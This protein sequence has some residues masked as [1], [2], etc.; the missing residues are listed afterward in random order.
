M[1]KGNDD[2]EEGNAYATTTDDWTL[3]DEDYAALS[4]SIQA[5]A[6]NLKG[7]DADID[8]DGEIAQVPLGLSA[9]KSERS[10]RSFNSLSDPGISKSSHGSRNSR[11][12]YAINSSYSI[13]TTKKAAP[14]AL[15]PSRRGLGYTNRSYGG[16]ESV[17]GHTTQTKSATRLRALIALGCLTVSLLLALLVGYGVTGQWITVTFMTTSNTAVEQSNTT[18]MPGPLGQASVYNGTFDIPD[19]EAMKIILPFDVENGLADWR[20]PFPATKR[21]DLPIFWNINKNGG[22]VVQKIVGQCLG[23]VLF[24]KE[25]AN[26]D[27]KTL[28]ILETSKGTRYINVDGTTPAGLQRADD[29]KLAESG[30][31]DVMFTPLMREATGI[32]SAKNPG[33]CFSIFRNP[34]ER[35]MALYQQ[36]KAENPAIA[37]MTLADFAANKLPNNELVRTLAGKA[38]NDDLSEEDLYL[39]MEIVR[40]KCVV[41]LVDL[42]EESMLRF[43]NYFGWAGLMVD[44][45]ALCQNGFLAPATDQRVP[46]PQKDSDAYNIMVGQN[47]LDLR[48]YDYVLHLYDVQGGQTRNAA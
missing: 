21:T 16:T 31:V 15:R 47:R 11:G 30:L 40:R 3:A 17:K 2:E 46:A 27:E 29:L 1:G 18:G 48:L 8:L 19:L 4:S 5:H 24:N 20:I 39:A 44:G 42:M 43:E 10:S 6:I 26:H 14:S 9:N 7:G 41:G 12:T 23:L 13:P 28:Q 45:V 34:L 36:A 33:R 38:T 35:S 22:T 32:F 25:G 37:S